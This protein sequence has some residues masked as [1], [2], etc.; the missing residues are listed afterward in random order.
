MAQRQQ[1]SVDDARARPLWFIPPAGDENRRRSLTREQVVA[2][3]LAVIGADGVEA[4]SM[5]ALATRLAGVSWLAEPTLMSVL[6]R[7]GAEGGLVYDLSPGSPL[8]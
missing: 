7:D 3:A 2:E 4:L 1:P 5:R 6:V 8:M